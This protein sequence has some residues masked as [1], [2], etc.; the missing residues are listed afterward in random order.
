MDIT[1]DYQNWQIEAAFAFCS[2][3]E[4]FRLPLIVTETQSTNLKRINKFLYL[5][6]AISAGEADD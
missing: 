3:R 5:I 6:Y 4:I 2:C 1:S